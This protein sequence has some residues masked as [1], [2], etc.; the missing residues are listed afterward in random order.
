MTMTTIADIAI[1]TPETSI[2]VTA[3]QY[4]DS[5]LPGTNL[6]GT[7]ADAATDATV[8][9]PTNAA[10]NR[11]AVDLG[12]AGDTSDEGAVV[13]FLVG[14]LPV[15][16][17]RDVILYHVSPGSQLAADVAASATL[18]TLL[19]PTIGVD[20]PTL[21]DNEPD[22]PD[23]SLEATDIVASNGVVH[24]IDRVLLPVD[25]PDNDAP[26]LTGI[27]AASGGT[28][29]DNAADFDLLLNAVL[30]AGLE[31]V[32]DDAAA[33]LTVFAPNDA[34]F[35][36]T[37]QALGF[38]G[39]DEAG[40]FDYIVEALTLLGKGDPLPLLTEILTYHV[41]PGS[42]QASQVL[43]AGTV[44]TLQ[45]GSLTVDAA[46]LSIADADPDL[47]DPTL[48]ATDIQAA[49]GIAH[50]IDGVLIPADIL[51][52]DGSNDVDFIIGDDGGEKFRTGRDNDFVDGNGG[53][54]IIL[55]GKGD[56]VGLG[57]TGHDIL[58]GWKGNDFVDGGEGNDRVYGGKGDDTV[59]GG[60][61]HDRLYGGKG[62][63]IVSGGTGNDKVSLGSGSDIFVFNAG[64]GHDRI[65]DFNT[66][67]DVIDLSSY[68]FD[69]FED[70][71]GSIHRGWWKT[72][73]DLGDGDGITFW[74][75]KHLD[76]D[77]FI[78]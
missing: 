55:L 37:A 8:F 28:F 77:D 30:T 33:D 5:N 26:T 1:A 11:L 29:D 50:V 68:D 22:L 53:N 71:S 17:I 31:G 18:Q 35:I 73:L 4:V 45:G 39:S 2:L 27:V 41:A 13:A 3:L 7:L 25:L 69:G 61:G 12:F 43:A 63:D 60:D 54:D 64:D 34:A 40:A 15:E 67:H 76:T 58:S 36:A 48:I 75:R 51:A 10:F 20:L 42:L 57:G 21:V 59:N 52:S 24:L 23:P 14:A 65:Y 62:D 49:N 46:T 56:D 66:R 78:F 19:G 38:H 72:T 16:T 74:G 70:I 44:G 6:V 47:P 32:L 9:A